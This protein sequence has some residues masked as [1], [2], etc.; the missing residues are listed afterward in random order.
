LVLSGCAAAEE[1]TTT[2]AGSTTDSTEEVAE[3]YEVYALLPQGSDQAYGTFYVPAMEAAAAELGINLT[4]TNSQYDGDKQ[5]SECEIAV[6]AKP[7]G[8]ILWPAV[9]DAVRPCLEAAEA[10]GIPVT[11]TNS[12]LFDADKALSRGYSGPDTYGQGVSSAEIMCGLVGDAEV[13]IIQLNGAPGN[14]TAIDRDNGFTE[15]IAANCPNVT[16]LQEETTDWTKAT[17]QQVASE[18]ITAQGLENIDGIYAADDSIAAG[19]IAALESRGVV[20][21]DY[22]ITS[23]GNTFLGNPLVIDGSLDGTVFQSSS[24][25]GTNAPRLMYD[26]LTGVLA[27]G[28]REVRFMPSVKVTIDN[29]SD[30]D[31]APEW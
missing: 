21:A 7:D 18:M 30:A 19:A 14:P 3:T 27:E 26:V 25:D 29:A 1:E 2:D 13:S 22:F 16:I 31:V 4:I 10:A 24:W 20:A 17:A 11:I 6:A 28:E 12:D 9:G 8:I 23:I 5:A 15:T